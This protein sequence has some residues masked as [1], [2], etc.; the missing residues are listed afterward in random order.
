M[1][2]AVDCDGT[3]DAAPTIFLSL[4]QAL[5]AAGHRV[6]VVT[7]SSS[8]VVTQQDLEDKA[9]YLQ[10]L[11]LGDAYDQLVVV[12]DPT[13]VN[14][15]EWLKNEGADI[16]IDNKKANARAAPCLALVPWATRE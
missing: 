9:T 3:I 6:V 7:G 4:L 5:R 15:T 2:V 16:L 14:K 11:G 8:E 1:L 10:N 12:A 13:D